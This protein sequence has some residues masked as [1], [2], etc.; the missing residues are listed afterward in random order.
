[1]ADS[2]LTA[3]QA[4][5][6]T[7][8]AA[9]E[10]G[11]L[12]EAGR[13]LTAAGSLLATAE[14]P[15]PPPVQR[16]LLSYLTAL[17]VLY[18]SDGNASAALSFFLDVARRQSAVPGQQP[19]ASEG[20]LTALHICDALGRLGRM[21]EAKRYAVGAVMILMEEAA[22]GG[23]G[24][25]PSLRDPA[26]QTLLA[27][28]HLRAGAAS[29][30]L[31]ELREALTA[32]SWGL[33]VPGLAEQLRGTLEES[34]LRVAEALRRQEEEAPAAAAPAAA[35]AQ[36]GGAPGP[37]PPPQPQQQQQQPP[38]PL[39]HR[40]S[41]GPAAAAAGV[42]ARTP[43][44]TRPPYPAAL[45]ET[46][47]V[48][49]LRAASAAAA[50]AAASPPRTAS[51]PA[52]PSPYGQRS[53]TPPSTA[54]GSARRPASQPRGG[55][56]S[57][58]GAATAAS[59]ASA[60]SA[61]PTAASAPRPASR[62][63]AL[64]SGA[65]APASSAQRLLFSP[66]LRT[67]PR[68]KFV[69]SPAARAHAR[70][71][72]PGWDASSAARSVAEQQ[73]EDARLRLDHPA[74][75]GGLGGEEGDVAAGA[76]G[77]AAGAAEA[78][79]AA[80]GRGR[81]S[82]ASPR[83]RSRAGAAAAS[84]SGSSSRPTT[85]DGSSTAAAVSRRSLS[86][87]PAGASRPAALPSVTFQPGGASAG[88]AAASG[89]S[90]A[91]LL[92]SPRIGGLEGPPSWV[93]EGGGSSLY[94]FHALPS[95]GSGGGGGG[96]RPGATSASSAALAAAA[97]AVSAAALPLPTPMRTEAEA[98]LQELREKLSAGSSAAS[99]AAPPAAQPQQ[100]QP[101]QDS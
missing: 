93:L 54:R 72:R 63:A 6:T 33:E 35:P 47:R 101:Q 66:F 13:E 36:G 40:T 94:E 31:G 7:G 4:H 76:G 86:T 68:V 91:W 43:G 74:L 95:D 38:L 100:Q 67:S 78:A 1:M 52:H 89:A 64:G 87:A 97:A 44:D 61:A 56:G 37:P 15:H 20:A 84:S 29:E 59:A 71:L 28:A 58:A 12:P 25:A 19:S 17:G 26:T 51:Q 3:V 14:A 8:L 23:G 92:P 99:V 16:A 69:L 10:R 22:A 70:G 50:A 65:A 88:K 48:L 46:R 11:A 2:F 32:L 41:A 82:S 34:L 96:G 81:G 27:V 49:G 5:I 9:L 57:G 98:F 55:G 42:T 60:A 75:L 90:P 18:L 21:A 77:G 73:R 24:A 53:S 39:P 80:A 45:D 83:P 62:G 85:R 79:A 30:A